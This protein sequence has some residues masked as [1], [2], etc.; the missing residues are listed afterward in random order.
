MYF[1]LYNP[2]CKK[3]QILTLGFYKSEIKTKN[4]NFDIFGPGRKHGGAVRIM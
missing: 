3:L 1:G 2:E 4:D